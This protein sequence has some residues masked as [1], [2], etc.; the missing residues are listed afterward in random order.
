MEYTGAFY[1]ERFYRVCRE[2]IYDIGYGGH[3]K[4]FA[5]D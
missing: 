2:A 4:R 5:S 1:I 3:C